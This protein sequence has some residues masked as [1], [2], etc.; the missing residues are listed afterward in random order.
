MSEFWQE[1]VHVA[2]DPAHILGE[3]TFTLVFDF[4]IL[5]LLV[6]F[7]KG[8]MNSFKKELHTELDEEHGIPPHE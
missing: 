3:L 1:Y 6:R 4:L 2:F 5:V 7:I 8:F